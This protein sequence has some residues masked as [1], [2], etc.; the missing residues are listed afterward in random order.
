MPSAVG[1]D[2]LVLVEMPPGPMLADASA[3]G[4]LGIPPPLYPDDESLPP[5]PDEY[6]PPPADDDE[7]A[8]FEPPLDVEPALTLDD[9]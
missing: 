2:V 1:I 6:P 7:L 4:A 8:A 5:P 9:D 3:L